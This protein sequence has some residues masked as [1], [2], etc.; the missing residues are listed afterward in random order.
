MSCIVEI[1]GHSI[2]LKFWMKLWMEHLVE[3]GIMMFALEV[4]VR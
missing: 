4:N 1:E 3:R 2:P